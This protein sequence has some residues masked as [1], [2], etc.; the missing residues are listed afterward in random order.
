LPTRIPPLDQHREFSGLL[1]TWHRRH[2]R[3]DLP[4]QQTR[5]PYRVWLSEIML[6]QTQVTAVIPY[7]QRFLERFPTLSEL[8]HAPVEAVMELWS[9]L[10]YYAR[11]RNLHHCARLVM[12]EHAGRFPE[13][14]DA[15]AQL[16]GIGRSTANAIG[17]FCF[18]AHAPILDGNVKRVLCR[19]YG[20]E[21]FPGT[22]AVEKHLW[23]LAETLLPQRDTPIYIQAQMDLGATACT[24]HRPV[25]LQ[26]AAACPLSKVCVAHATGRIA[27]LP[28][29]RPRKVLPQREIGVLLL[30]ADGKILFQRRPS[31]GI[32]GGLLSLPEF[33]VAE[34]PQRHV[35][36]TC[37]CVVER[38]APL[39]PLRHTFTHFHLTLHPWSGEGRGL[40][41]T[42]EPS[43]LCWINTDEL[44]SAALPT[45][46]R[47]IVEGFLQGAEHVPRRKRRR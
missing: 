20:I 34:D 18:G 42:A 2:G 15:I 24:R 35:A 16:P 30:H 1:I 46:I 3:H 40:P 12:N 25:C 9:G 33:P 11:A 26:S 47:R 17:V 21:G 13:H 28:T 41:H 8:A 7:Y 36:Q 6:Q 29:P 43:G 37:N 10:G 39:A 14:P 32:W 27:E 22:S 38:F 4:W 31:S 45:P 19:A 23:T 44:D 5:D